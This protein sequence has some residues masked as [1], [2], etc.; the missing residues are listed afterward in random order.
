M[1]DC[2][3]TPDDASDPLIDDPAVDS[4]AEAFLACDGDI[5]LLEVDEELV[6]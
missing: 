1:A 3:S 4:L 5:D 6:S 2:H